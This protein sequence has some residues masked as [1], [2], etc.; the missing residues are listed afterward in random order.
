M[1]NV[2]TPPNPYFSGINFNPSFFLSVA[3]NY[4]TEAIA[5]S[6]YLRL[7]GG[8]LTGNLGIKTTPIAELD[9]NGKAYI[10]NG[11]GTF[12]GN[13]VLGTN[14]TRL[15]LHP[16]TPTEPPFAL[17][18]NANEL[19]Y[20]TRSGGNHS[21]YT[22]TTERMRIKSDGNVGIG[23]ADPQTL[24]HITGKTF[25]HNGLGAVPA[26]GTY[27][28]DGTRL[29]LWPGTAIQTPYSIGIG[30]AALWY[31]VPSDANHIFYTGIDERLRINSGGHLISTQ[32]I[33]G[34]SFIAGTTSY[35]LLIGPPGATNP[36]TIQ[37]VQQG[38]GFNQNIAMQ[39]SGGNVGIGTATGITDKLTVNG[40]CRATSVIGTTVRG[41]SELIAGGD[42]FQ[43]I[44]NGYTSPTTAASIETLQQGVGNNGNLVLQRS[45]GNV[46][47][48]TTNANNILQVGDGARLRISNDS[49]DY[50]MI[51]T[52]QIDDSANTC[53]YLNGNTLSGNA[54][55]IAYYATTSTG[56]HS[57]FTNGDPS[58]TLATLSP[59]K[60]RFF[61]PLRSMNC[62]YENE[63]QQYPFTSGMVNV[64]GTTL[65]G[66]FIPVNDYT[67]SLMTCAFSHDS[68]VYTYWRGHVTIG[69]NNDILAVSS[70]ISSSNLLVEN[71]VQQTTFISYI[72]VVPTVSYSVQTLLRVKI[73]G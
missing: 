9:I 51:G 39:S 49:S 54:G 56:R 12:P 33:T 67:N 66:Y 6:K 14:G 10:N 58:N 52:K 5:N 8:I 71:F 4:L 68:T 21:F 34:T 26:V 62:Q 65:N 53:I 1:S 20:G 19:W 38:I 69:K 45:A 29:I 17:G 25:I 3:S 32:S 2:D 43:L 47:I 59:D 35:Q 23:T 16:G 18:Y 61:K 40:T 15:I 36:A 70:A 55:N 42:T 48:R 11:F 41:S 64:S 73:Y 44:L 30:P 37:T 50:S 28:S 13:G 60:C 22:G 24:L 57:F 63:G 7:I 72:R 31:A 27:G 46:G